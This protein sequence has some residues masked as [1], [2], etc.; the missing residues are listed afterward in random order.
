MTAAARRAAVSEARSRHPQLSERHACQVI[1]C[2]LSSQRYRSRR[3]PR[4]ALRTRLCELA[5]ERV[6]FGY[7]RL[8]VLL[9]REGVVVNRKC[10]YRLYREEGLA[11]RKKKRKRVAVARQ[12]MPAPERLND[13]WAMDFMSDTLRGGRRF[14]ILN[15]IDVLSREG[16]ASEVDT[17]L[18]ARR[19]VQAVDVIAL[20]RGYPARIVVDN[21]PEF[22]SATLDA[23]A[24]EH[25]VTLDFIDPGKPIQNAVMESYN[26]RMRDECLN[27]NLWGTIPEARDG[28]GAHRIDYNDV[29]PHGSL[30]HRTPSEFARE[31]RERDSGVRIA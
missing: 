7:R 4:P 26:G 6:R 5:H 20:E 21:G 25:G 18:P 11:V 16:L 2:A 8:H 9:V 28:I 3:D 12:P 27:V 10:V 13:C 19:V 1:G 14:R 23:W 31:L 17:S 30:N 22:R 15:L 24:Y 29:R